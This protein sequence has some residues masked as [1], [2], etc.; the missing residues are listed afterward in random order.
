MGELVP[1]LKYTDS[2]LDALAESVD[3][4]FDSADKLSTSRLAGIEK[5]VDVATEAMNRRLEGMNEIKAMAAASAA[6]Y[7][8]RPEF[9]VQ[10]Q[11]LSE[12]MEADH[13]SLDAKIEGGFK[14]LEERFELRAKGL[15]TK[16]DALATALA[17]KDKSWETFKTIM[18]GKTNQALIAMIVSIFSAAAGIALTFLLVHSWIPTPAA[19]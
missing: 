2:R 13:A 16:I 18:I 9:A 4:R 11:A 8:P 17:D 12:K 19:K 7:L 10:H 6:T 1:L 15:D 14:A 3:R 5:A